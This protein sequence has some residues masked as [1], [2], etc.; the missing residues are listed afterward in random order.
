[1][2]ASP[3]RPYSGSQVRLVERVAEA[4]AVLGAVGDPGAVLGDQLPAGS[5]Q[6]AGRPEQ[7]VHR[8]SMDDAAQVLPGN[9]DGQISLPI[10]VEVVRADLGREASQSRPRPRARRPRRNYPGWGA[11][12]GQPGRW[13]TRL[14][15]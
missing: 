2:V 8:P 5:W 14:K 10:A 7:D 12:P 4:V 15:R 6:A 3:S 1:M 11:D 9:P 13:L